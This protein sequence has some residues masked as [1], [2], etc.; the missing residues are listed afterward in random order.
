MP[1]VFVCHSPAERDLAQHLA[2]RL[3]RTAQA[4][5]WL[6]ETRAESGPAVTDIWDRGLSCTAVLL[7]LSP[8]AV[9]ARS[10]RATWGG[11]LEHLER[12]GQP[13][14]A[15]ALVRSCN[16]PPLLE[17]RQFFRWEADPAAAAREI[18][19]WIVGLHGETAHTF[20]A[21]RL[22]HFAGREEELDGLFAALVDGGGAHVISGPPESGKSALAQEFARRAAAHFRDVLW[23]A[24]G[25]R[26]QPWLS[27][28]LAAQLGIAPDQG[29]E[30]AWMR[31]AEQLREH[32]VLLVLDDLEEEAAHAFVSP[33]RGA[34]LMTGPALD[35]IGSIGLDQKKAP[36]PEAPT[37][38]GDLRLWQAMAV[39]SPREAPLD[40]AALA[41]GMDTND[42][43][44]AAERLVA[45]RLI[46]PVNARSGL[47]RIS[48]SSSRAARAGASAQE[49]SRR[50]V[51][52]LREALSLSVFPQ[53]EPALRWALAKEWTAGV[54]LA[55]RAFRFLQENRRPLEG[56]AIMDQLVRAAERRGDAQ[57][58]EEARWELSWLRDGTGSLRAAPTESQQLALF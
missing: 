8:D 33:G 13:P 21:A 46:D 14:V 11:V 24:C 25:D 38:A 31:A 19:Q 10:G 55:R 29:V 34:V 49:L 1:D 41:A 7:L 17:R 28:E 26:T 20:S 37:H 42:A 23:L 57:V 58:A 56:A 54:D 43:Q 6:E 36:R 51:E 9:P 12:A 4:N 5:I 16:Y 32:R 40:F 39:C 35:L 45:L 22:P 15:S 47:F 30:A 3:R 52:A 50:H 2:E 53:V 44:I 18:Q 48:R 27:G